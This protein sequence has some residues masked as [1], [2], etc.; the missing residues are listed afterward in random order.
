MSDDQDFEYPILD[1]TIIRA[2]QHAAGA[3]KRLRIRRRALPRRPRHEDPPGGARPWL[4]C[5]DP[6]DRGQAGDAPQAEALL[7]HDRAAAVIA[8]TACDADHLRTVIARAGAV[9]VIPSTPSPAARLPLD[10]AP[11]RERHLIERC[12]NKL[13][14]FR[15][16]ATRHE[17]TARTYQPIVTRA[18][19]ILWIR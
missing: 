13:R 10:R 8:D 19:T 15:R 12:L 2:H 9:A 4:P 7:A 18:A 11:Y 1:S 14:Q 3:K 6:A 17:K 16:V 5:P